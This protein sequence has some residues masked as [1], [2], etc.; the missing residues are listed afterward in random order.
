MI[1]LLDPMGL[2]IVVIVYLL[3]GYTDYAVVYH[4]IKYGR[5]EAER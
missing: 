5:Q 2:T 1:F 3:I 4:V